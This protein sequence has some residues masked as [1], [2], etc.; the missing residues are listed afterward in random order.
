MP[1]PF[2]GIDTVYV[3]KE[4][5]I[6]FFIGQLIYQFESNHLDY[7]YPKPLSHLGLPNSLERIDA[8]LVWGHNNET[9]FYSG[10]LYWKSVYHLFFF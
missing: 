8:A 10:T 3:N 7:G 1:E 2:T 6:V 5:K 9:Y 4:Q